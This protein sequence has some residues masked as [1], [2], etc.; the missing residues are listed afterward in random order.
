ME[1][2]GLP[3]TLRV[4]GRAIAGVD[5][6]RC[7]GPEGLGHRAPVPSVQNRGRKR[8]GLTTLPPR[9]ILVSRGVFGCTASGQAVTSQDTLDKSRWFSPFVGWETGGSLF[10]DEKNPT[11]IHTV[12]TNAG[13]DSTQGPPRPGAWIL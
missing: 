1:N 6:S 2:V 9:S 10:E 7:E 12:G 5:F 11:G 13:S 3:K 4:R 8:R